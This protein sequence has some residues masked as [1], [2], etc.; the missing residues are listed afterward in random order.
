MKS[1]KISVISRNYCFTQVFHEIPENSSNF[2]KSLKNVVRDFMKSLRG[3][4]Q[5]IHLVIFLF[6]DTTE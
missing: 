1:L 5:T 3:N 2:V 4:K 6:I